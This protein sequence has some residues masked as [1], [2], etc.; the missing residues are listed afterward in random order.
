MS[1]VVRVD[2]ERCAW[3]AVEHR[4]HL[5]VFY[6]GNPNND[7]FPARVYGICNDH[8]AA[9]RRRL[10]KVTRAVPRITP[11]YRSTRPTY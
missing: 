9:L 5:E 11:P 2:V 8:A 7:D 1:N 4:A 10:A 3:G 6:P